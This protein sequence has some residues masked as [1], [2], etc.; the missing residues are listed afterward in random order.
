MAIHNISVAFCIFGFPA[1]ALPLRPPL[2]APHIMAGAKWNRVGEPF[3]W[4]TK[5]SDVPEVWR[6]EWWQEWECGR[7]AVHCALDVAS[8]PPVWQEQWAWRVERV[9]T[10][11]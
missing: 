6:G 3:F 8:S 9:W 10:V 1:A 11:C 2:A 4:W 5:E 7:W